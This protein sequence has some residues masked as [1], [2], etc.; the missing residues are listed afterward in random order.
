MIVHRAVGE[1]VLPVGRHR[2]GRDD[3]ARVDPVLPRELRGTEHRSSRAARGR[4]ALETRQRI[5][6]HRGGE[7]LL[8]GHR[9]PEDRVRVVRR[10]PACLAGNRGEGL[11]PGPVLLPILTS[12]RANSWGAIGAASSHCP[13]RRI[14][15]INRASGVGRSV[16][17]SR[18]APGTIC[19]KPRARTHPATPLSTAC[20]AMYSA[21]DPVAQLLLTLNTGM[22]LRPIR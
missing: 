18:S 4:A 3:D 20:R 10:V 22:P 5:G 17:L 6:D 14:T 8:H 12:R 13:S 9:L 21:V 7:D 11:G 15:S 1:G 16:H 19:S 2:L